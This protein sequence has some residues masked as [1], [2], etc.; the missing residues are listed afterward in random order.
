SR[1]WTLSPC[2]GG[3]SMLVSPCRR[4]SWW[5][6]GWLT[7]AAGP[8]SSSTRRG[9]R[10]CWVPTPLPSSASWSGLAGPPMGSTPPTRPGSWTEAWTD[11]LPSPPVRHEPYPGVVLLQPGP[12][13]Q[14]AVHL[15]PEDLG[16]E[17]GHR[18]VPT[19]E[20]AVVAAEE[21]DGPCDR[22]ALREP[23]QHVAVDL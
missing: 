14:D 11:R 5:T 22:L 3:C 10:G 12:V 15:A 21:D 4:P 13:P 23:E 1:R 16:Q 18:H 17:G 6:W 7:V 19:L 20:G 9:A 2:V 8:W